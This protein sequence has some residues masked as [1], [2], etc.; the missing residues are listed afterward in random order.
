MKVLQVVIMSNHE[1]LNKV[2][3]ELSNNG[4]IEMVIPLVSPLRSIMS[5]DVEPMP[6]FGGFRQLAEGDNSFDA[7]LMIL[8][9]NEIQLV[10]D[11]VKSIS[12]QEGTQK[13]ITFTLPINN[14]EE[15]IS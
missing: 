14:Y 5:S 15:F 11:I 13:S 12:S 4:K 3:Q 2:C 10:K 6:I 7:I 8:D 9:E 1:N